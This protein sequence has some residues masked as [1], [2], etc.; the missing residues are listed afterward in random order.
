MSGHHSAQTNFLRISCSY[1]A[2]TNQQLHFQFIQRSHY[3][4]VKKTPH[5]ASLLSSYLLYRTA[6]QNKGPCIELS[7]GPQAGWQLPRAANN[8]RHVGQYLFHPWHFV[9]LSE[10]GT[11][12]KKCS[13]NPAHKLIGSVVFPTGKHMTRPILLLKKWRHAREWTPPVSALTDW[14]SRGWRGFTYLLTLVL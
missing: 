14:L 3:I 5:C 10:F 2:L 4:A 13:Y 8:V 6:R 11:E 1:F 12:K 7:M 9:S